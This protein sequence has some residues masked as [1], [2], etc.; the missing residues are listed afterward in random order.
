MLRNVHTWTNLVRAMESRSDREPHYA[1]HAY[2]GLLSAHGIVC[3][4]SRKGDCL[5]NAVAE[6]FFGSLKRAWT[7]HR[8]YATRQE[9]R[10]DVLD[11]IER[12]YNSRRKHSY[13][14]YVSPNAYEKIAR[15][16]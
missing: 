6:R 2:R 12:F 4:M 5:D 10:D 14:G 15:V 9:A 16:A 7:T 11:Y 3:S 1:S 13:L 8:L